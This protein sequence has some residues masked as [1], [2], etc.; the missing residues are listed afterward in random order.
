MKVIFVVMILVCASVIVSRTSDRTATIWDS[1]G[2]S[3][4]V[5]G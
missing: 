5:V 1:N 2:N 3:T 4:V